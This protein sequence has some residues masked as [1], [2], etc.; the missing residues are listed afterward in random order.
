MEG[1]IQEYADKLV[2]G[3]GYANVAFRALVDD[4]YK[5]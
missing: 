3:C 5:A 4:C 2:N 1:I